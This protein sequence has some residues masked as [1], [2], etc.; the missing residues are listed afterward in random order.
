LSEEEKKLMMNDF[1]IFESYD[2]E[3]FGKLIS[4]NTDIRSLLQSANIMHRAVKHLDELFEK[5][6][7]EEE[8]EYYRVVAAFDLVM[9]TMH[10]IECLASLL[11]AYRKRSPRFH[12]EITRYSLDD[13]ATEILN[14][15]RT[16]QLKPKDVR[17]LF[18][19]PV[20]GDEQITD[21]SCNKILNYMRELSSFYFPLREPYR[22]YKHGHPFGVIKWVRKKGNKVI[23]HIPLLIYLEQDTVRKNSKELGNV[24]QFGFNWGGLLPYDPDELFQKIRIVFNLYFIAKYNCHMQTYYPERGLARALVSENTRQALS[25]KIK[26]VGKASMK[27]R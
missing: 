16:G 19:F 4:G 1:G 3:T 17:E 6:L 2:H 20:I 7:P 23:G 12:E 10:S 15:S 18:G 5:P 27:S 21:E 8:K 26:E 22:R 24:W 13:D 14:H 9:K 11:A 25:K